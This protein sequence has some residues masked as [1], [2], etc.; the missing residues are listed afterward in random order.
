MG[1]GLGVRLKR[2]GRS[3]TRVKILLDS[4]VGDVHTV[5]SG[6]VVKS[7]YSLHLPSRLF[8]IKLVL[9]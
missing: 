7:F 1:A 4:E 5:V 2:M 9:L 8:T 6:K 3:R